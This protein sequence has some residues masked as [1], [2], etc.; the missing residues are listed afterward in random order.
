MKKVLVIFYL[1][2]C[3]NL[4]AQ[5]LS[6]SGRVEILFV[7]NI[8]NEQHLYW[9]YTEKAILDDGR[10]FDL[11]ACTNT[12]LDFALFCPNVL[13]SIEYT[14]KKSRCID[15][16]ISK[17]ARWTNKGQLIYRNSKHTFSNLNGDTLMISFCMSGKAF[18]ITEETCPK[19]DVHEYSNPVNKPQKQFPILLLNEIHKIKRLRKLEP[20]YHK[21]KKRYFV[22][23]VM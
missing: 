16:V 20:K 14:R 15:K 11:A 10:N 7:L 6:V 13:E 19:Y 18:I 3:V 4:S 9:T 22:K 5:S 12:H 8:F 2:I 17:Y 23:G 21:F 1:A